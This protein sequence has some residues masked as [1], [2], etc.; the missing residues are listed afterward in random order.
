MLLRRASE[1]NREQFEAFRQRL[2][3]RLKVLVLQTNDA[4]QMSI[5][6][7]YHVVW[8]DARN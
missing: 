7:E 1:C 6:T 5:R 2:K 3:S 4:R 8:T